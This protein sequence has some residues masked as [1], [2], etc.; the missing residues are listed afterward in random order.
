MDQFRIFR[1]E[2]V[3]AL[4][5]MRNAIEVMKEAIVSRKNGDMI[6]PPRE[7]FVAGSTAMV[8]TPG[9]HRGLKA[10]GL[11]L[12]LTGVPE[13]DQIVAL[14]DSGRGHLKAIAVGEYLGRLRTGAIGGAAI[15]LMSRKDSRILGII[16]F[17]EQAWM[18][19]RA[20][21]AIRNIDEIRVYR[22]NR[23]LLLLLSER[24]SREFGVTVRAMDDP[25]SCVTGSDIIV[26]ATNSSAPVIRGEWLS[27]GAHINSLGPKLKGRSELGREI[28]DFCTIVASDFPD[29]LARDSSFVFR[30]HPR[31]VKMR[32]LA[33]LIEEGKMRKREEISL[34][35]SHGLSGTEISL[36]DYMCRKAEGTGRE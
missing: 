20:A 12:Y 9:A 28:L 8:W 18:Q 14:W 35:L 33:L 34:F 22:R 13:K 36:L 27:P 6:S 26:T 31:I 30:D 29:L 21:L 25:R 23:E 16:G 1:D 5:D 32:D 10:I 11:R 15:D 2:D 3:A 19:A 7:S 24:A 17:G 4:V